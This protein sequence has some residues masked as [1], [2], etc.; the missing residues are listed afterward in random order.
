MALFGILFILVLLLIPLIQDQID[1]LSDTLPGILNWMQNSMIPWIMD[2]LG[3]SGVVNASTLKN[4]IA[5]NIT[6]AGGVADNLLKALLHSGFQLVELLVTLILIPVVTFYLLCDW[7][8]VL[9][10]IRNLIP[11]HVE[12][13]IV[14]LVQECDTVLSAFFRG[15]LL[16]MLALGIIYSVGLMLIGLQL[17]LMIGLI[18]GILSIV[19]YLGFISG[20]IA[21]SIAAFV[22]FGTF[23]SVLFVWLVFAVGHLIEHTFLTPK[24][25]GDRI[26]LHP[27]AVIFAI[28]A[29]GCL[30]GF[31]GVLL[32]LPVASVVMVWVR[33]LHKRYRRSKLYQ[34]T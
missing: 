27:V 13:I 26:G 20:I 32:A 34:Q 18:S 33:Y 28:L 11:R 31:M 29:G 7:D 15:Q 3:L 8:R 12:P 22:Q 21:A 24:L 25:V 9:L 4:V 2:H 23:S 17:G 30:F 5:N 1:V 10:G 19:P 6:K 16:V 14:K